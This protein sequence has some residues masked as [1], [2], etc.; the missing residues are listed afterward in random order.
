MTTTRE[1]IRAGA[2]SAH[3]KTAPVPEAAHR[4]ERII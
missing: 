4:K 3:R 2:L 1:A